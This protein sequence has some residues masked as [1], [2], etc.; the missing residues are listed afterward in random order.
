MNSFMATYNKRHQMDSIMF[1]NSFLCNQ[2][3][4]PLTMDQRLP[5]LISREASFLV[6]QEVAKIREEERHDDF[7]FNC[8]QK[9]S[10]DS[11]YTNVQSSFFNDLQPV[12][13]TA[14]AS[15]KQM[16]TLSAKTSMI[17]CDSDMSDLNKVVDKILNSKRNPAVVQEKK[18]RFKMTYEQ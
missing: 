15:H 18:R 5:S 4:R 13:S 16:P 8:E 17:S 10:Y 14:S 2:G 11:K 3:D 1:K 9:S 12:H 7:F 6:Q